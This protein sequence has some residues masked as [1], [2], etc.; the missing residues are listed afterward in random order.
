LCPCYLS[1]FIAAPLTGTPPPNSFEEPD[2]HRLIPPV[3]AKGIVCDE[4]DE[5]EDDPKTSACCGI[6]RMKDSLA[7]IA[8]TGRW[9]YGG[10][11]KEPFTPKRQPFRPKSLQ[12]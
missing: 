2:I 10:V 8:T 12:S 11:R 4:E 3:F 5:Y 6:P 1:A 9:G 7:T